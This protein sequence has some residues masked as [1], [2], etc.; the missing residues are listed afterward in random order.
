MAGLAS[1]IEP[2][3]QWRLPRWTEALVPSAVQEMMQAASGPDFV[4]FALGLPAPEFLPNAACVTASRWVLES[5]ADALQ[6]RPPLNALK[7]HIVGLMRRRGLECRKQ[8]IVITTGAQQ[9]LNLLCRLL[10]ER[11]APILVEEAL[12]PGFRQPAESCEARFVPVPSD[13]KTGI[14]V[15]TVRRLLAGGLKPAL[16]YINGGAHNPLGISLSEE[17]KLAL[18]ELAGRYQVPIIEDDAYGL[19]S[20][21]EHPAPPVRSIDNQM[22]CY[23]GSLSKILA[24][25][26]RIGWI[27]APEWATP[28]LAT[29]KEG[30]DLDSC[31]LSQRIASR[32]FDIVDVNAQIEKLISAY[33]SRRDA[34]LQAL[35]QEFAQFGKWEESNG[36][37]FVWVRLA[38][39]IDTG[40]L[41]RDAIATERI[42]FLPGQAFSVS[43][44][45]SLKNC[46]RLTYSN[47]APDRI[48]E[49]IHRLALLL[50]SHQKRARR[51]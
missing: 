51:V 27:I 26:L 12:Y 8:Q 9:A 45:A 37:M 4:S 3:Q 11:G 25:A 14:D 48:Q 44:G 2:D 28:K 43:G 18:A 7:E 38:D 42:A 16:I 31:T 10:I 22:A 19:L 41:L 49:G 32:L 29:L 30:T 23:V 24:P 5:T 13:P 6:Y 15:D 36:G 50:K 34:M 1:V 21:D 40:Q 20:F 17:K 39:G 47:L 33:R 46:L 35:K